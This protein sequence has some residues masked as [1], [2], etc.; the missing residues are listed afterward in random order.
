MFRIAFLVTRSDQIGGSHIHVRDLAF[1]LQEDGYEVAVFIGGKGPVIDH[2]KNF[3]LNVI[4]IPTMRRNI[5]PFYDIKAYSDLKKEIFSFHPDI[6]TSHS[7]KAGFLGRI[8]ANK[9][10]IPVIFTAH[11]WA[12]TDGKSR[13]KK[14]LYRLLEK[15]VVPITDKI[16][17]VSDF[18]RELALEQLPIPEERIVSIHNGMTDIKEEF[19]AQQENQSPV[20]IVMVAR[21]DHQ[22]DQFELLNATHKI[23]NIH[24]HFVGDGPLKN[25][26]VELAKDLKI[27]NK[28]TFWGELDSVIKVLAKCQIFALISNWEGFPCSTLEAMRAG[29]PTVVSDVGGAAEAVEHN[30]TGY[31]VTKGDVDTLRTVIKELVHD[32]ER[33]KSMGDAA[34]KRYED[35]YTFEKMYEKTLAVYQDVLNAQ[36]EKKEEV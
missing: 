24:V 20:N 29:L 8:I 19:M 35:F 22:K 4:N 27:E 21:F 14:K 31:V 18:D 12:F 16:I 32:P 13:L 9:L 6:I 1:A 23:E 36:P 2:F 15:S 30:S 3:G 10:N 5:S 7:S 26:V 25:E 34:R 28:V 11:G 17:A 33:R